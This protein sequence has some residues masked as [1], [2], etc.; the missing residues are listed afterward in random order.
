MPF[1]INIF[2]T[3]ILPDNEPKIILPSP[4]NIAKAQGP[5]R[6]PTTLLSPSAFWANRDA[7][8]AIVISLAPAQSINTIK[9]IKVLF[10]SKSFAPVFLF[11]A[12][13]LI[14]GTKR[15]EIEFIKG[16]IPQIIGIIVQFKKP[17]AF[18]RKVV[19]KTVKV[20]PQQ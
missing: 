2:L 6:S 19:I 15:N 1:I 7:H 10:L 14:T 12:V 8:C 4:I 3:E 17:N 5:K 9:Q 13:G 11:S 20:C 18:R 16:I